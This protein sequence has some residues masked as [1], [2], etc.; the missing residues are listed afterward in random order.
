MFFRPRF[1][2]GGSETTIRPLMCAESNVIR[3]VPRP[4]CLLCGS[5][6]ELLYRSLPDRLFGAPG[7]SD[8]KRCPNPDCG[9]L[10]LDPKPLAEDL[11][12]AYKQYFTHANPE[13]RTTVTARFR[14]FLYHCYQT[15]SSLPA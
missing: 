8:F 1:R 3:T 2:S 9:L 4:E 15:G 12:L 13:G 10:W 5:K 11:H 6:G 14:E 7:T